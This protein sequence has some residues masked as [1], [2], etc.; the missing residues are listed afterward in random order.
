MSKIERTS[1]NVRAR[2]FAIL[3]KNDSP[4]NSTRH[5]LANITKIARIT[6][7]TNFLTSSWEVRKFCKKSH[8]YINKTNKFKKNV[9]LE[10]E[11]AKKLGS[12]EVP[13]FRKNNKIFYCYL[14]RLS[15]KYHENSKTKNLTK[16]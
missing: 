3:V 14:K 6:N 8:E 13:K 11:K 9:R 15:N 7:L 4:E 12:W 10:R 2:F 5:S 16:F 1:R